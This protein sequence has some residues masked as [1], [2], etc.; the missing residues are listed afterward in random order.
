M[1]VYAFPG[2]RTGRITLTTSVDLLILM[3][4]EQAEQYERGLLKSKKILKAKK[5]A[6]K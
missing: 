6:N 5:A 3:A 4:E 1:L 2:N